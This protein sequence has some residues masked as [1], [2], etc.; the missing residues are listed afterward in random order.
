MADV[1]EPEATV[2]IVAR[3]ERANVGGAVRSA[4]RQGRAVEVLVVDDHSDDGTAT[5]AAEAGARVVTNRGAGV[6]DARNTAVDSASCDV[7]AWLDADDRMTPS[8]LDV[9][10][11]WFDDPSV[12]LVAGC[13]AFVDETGRPLTLQTVPPDTERCLIIA[14]A[15]NPFNQSAVAFRRQQ[16][17]ELGGYRSGAETD[18]AEDYD[19]WAR[20]LGAK[21]R[22]VGVPTTVVTMT[23][24]RNSE[25]VRSSV[26][27]SRRASAIRSDLWAAHRDEVPS[28]ATTRRLGRELPFEWREPTALDPYALGLFRL[29]LRFAGRGDVRTAVWFATACIA[30]GPVRSVCSATRAAWGIHRIRRARGWK[31]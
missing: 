14:L 21:L 11:P 5:V 29:G 8:A 3:N 18:A 31:A 16:I 28:W 7:I 12:V 25:S 10:L 22:V 26:P 17:V 15:F 6:V 24:R 19:L 20:V 1:T 30:M 4:L 2:A 9:M 23:V 13:A 27:Q